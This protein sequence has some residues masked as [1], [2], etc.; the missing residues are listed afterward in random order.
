MN[1][2]MNTKN[3]QHDRGFL[4]YNFN[5][6][7]VNYSKITSI[8]IKHLKHYMPDIPVAVCGDH[9]EG[10]D[11][12]ISKQDVKH[13]QRTYIH[14][15]KRQEETWLN[16]TRD[17]SLDI[18]PFDSTVLLDSDFFV[19]SNQLALLFDSDSPILL[20][21]SVY[22]IKEDHISK[23]YLGNTTIMKKWATIVKFD[24]SKVAENFFNLWQQTLKNYEYYM[25]L[26]GWKNDGTVWNDNAV[27]VVHSQ[28]TN[29][30]SMSKQFIIPWPQCFANFQCDIE[31]VDIDCIKIKDQKSTMHIKQDV[32]VLN[33]QELV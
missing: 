11:I 8:C 18:T 4:I 16:L 12:H 2:T 22:N 32:H 31:S 30:D 21:D 23:S 17:L 10:C 25:K 1:Y 7:S 20:H 3:L 24:H 19:L 5:T 27:S 9:V 33:K 6:D 14:K 15:G 28:I 29:Y 13:N 26:Y